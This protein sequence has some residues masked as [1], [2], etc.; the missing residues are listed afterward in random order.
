MCALLCVLSYV[1]FYMCA[2]IC[3]LKC[4]LFYVHSNVCSHICSF[5][6]GLICVLS[7]VCSHMCALMCVL[8]HVCSHVRSY[9]S[10]SPLLSSPFPPPLFWVSC[11]DNSFFFGSNF[12]CSVFFFCHRGIKH[13]IFTAVLFTFYRFDFFVHVPF[14]VLDL[15][16]DHR[17]CTICTRTLACSVTYFYPK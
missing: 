17:T 11:R 9:V 8:S 16:K 2:L 4:L 13:V 1:C 6:C 10:L 14:L 3:A 5:L 12:R 7:S 15:L